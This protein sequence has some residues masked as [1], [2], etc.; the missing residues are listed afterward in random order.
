MADNVVGEMGKG[1][2]ENGSDFQGYNP[3]SY[4]VSQLHDRCLIGPDS[5]LGHEKEEGL[6]MLAL[7]MFFM[8]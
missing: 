4:T 7:R 1:K 8:R 5:V 3:Q 2:L 6:A